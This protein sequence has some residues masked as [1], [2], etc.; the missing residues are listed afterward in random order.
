MKIGEILIKEKVISEEELK[1][2]LEKQQ[3]NRSKLGK[4]FVEMGLIDYMDLI[5]YLA[6]SQVRPS[7]GELL[8]TIGLVS[9]NQI[10][11]AL[12]I[13]EKQRAKRIGYI[14]VELGYLDK[15]ILAQ[16]LTVQAKAFSFKDSKSELE[17]G[18]AAIVG[19]DQSRYVGEIKNGIMHGKGIYADAECRYIGDFFEGD[20]HGEGVMT[21]IDGYILHSGSWKKGQPIKKS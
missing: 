7:I 15:T 16:F 11:E 5:K 19:D 17:F 9:E 2:A 1:K 4:I 18:C 12:K 14:L 21:A 10:L 8:L 20:F 13:Q 3:I 6:T